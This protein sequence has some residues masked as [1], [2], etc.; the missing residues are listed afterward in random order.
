MEVLLV[1]GCFRDN[2]DKDGYWVEV[3]NFMHA[4]HPELSPSKLYP[5]KYHDYAQTDHVN[6]MDTLRSIWGWQRQR[7]H[8]AGRGD[9]SSW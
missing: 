4:R 1:F 5:N 6:S 8:E 2:L 3:H 7:L 9:L